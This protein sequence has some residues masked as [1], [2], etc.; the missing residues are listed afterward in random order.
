MDLLRSSSSTSDSEDDDWDLFLYIAHDELEGGQ[1]DA[2]TED[3]KRWNLIDARP[4]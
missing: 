1:D 2:D 4:V 3:N